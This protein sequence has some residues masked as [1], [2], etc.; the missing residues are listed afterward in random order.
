MRRSAKGSKAAVHLIHRGAVPLPLKGKD[1][2][3]LKVGEIAI[4]ERS[5][6]NVIWSLV[7]GLFNRYCPLISFNTKSGIN[8]SEKS[9]SSA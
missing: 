8:G 6:I 9:R 4:G 7:S 2:M 5:P 3:P 1:L